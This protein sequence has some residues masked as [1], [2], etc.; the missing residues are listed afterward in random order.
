MRVKTSVTLPGEL[1]QEIDRINPNRSAFL[2]RAARTYLDAVAKHLR[3][4]KDAAILNRNAVRLNREA[5]DVLKYQHLA[6]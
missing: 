6:E 1:L 5:T 2:E 3:D 4:S